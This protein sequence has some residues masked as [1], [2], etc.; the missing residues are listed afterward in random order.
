MSKPVDNGKV[1]GA[2][3]ARELIEWAIAIGLAVVLAV[4]VHTWVGQLVT[5]DG[6]SMQPA[7][8]TGEKVLIGKVEYYFNQPKRGD[9]VLAR[10]PGS[11]QNFIKRVIALGGERILVND[12]SVYINGK[13]LDEPYISEPIGYSME[14]LTVPEDCVF[15]M[16]DNRNNST[17]SHKEYVGPIPL[18]MVEGR[19]YALVW[20]LGKM[21]KLTDYTG[22]LEE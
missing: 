8:W 22:K 21:V 12:G 9:I 20:P 6:P 5:V 15:L 14:E 3:G 16:G 19:A 2:A 18:N 13:K 17:D 7:L 10:F 1:C 4:S 11:D